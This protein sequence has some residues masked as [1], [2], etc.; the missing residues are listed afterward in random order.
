MLATIGSNEYRNR[1]MAAGAAP[2]PLTPSAASTGNATASAASGAIRMP[3]SAIDGIVCTMF[4]APSTAFRRRG[5]RWQSTPSGS[6]TIT[7][8]PS[9]PRAS[10][11]CRCASCA[12]RV[13]FTAYSR[14]IERS[15]K[16]PEP[17][18]ASVTARKHAERRDAQR[19]AGSHARQ[20]I[21]G[22]QAERDQHDP[23]SGAG[24]DAHDAIAGGRQDVRCR[25]DRDDQRRHADERGQ[26]PSARAL[27]EH[28][29]GSGGRQREIQ[30]E[31]GGGQQVVQRARLARHDAVG[32]EDDQRQQ[33]EGKRPHQ[34][35]QRAQ[36]IDALH[37][38]WSPWL[39]GR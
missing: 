3:K 18:A 27:D 10:S 24:C 1:A 38:V 36:V 2:M 12:N 34:A 19:G 32:L 21:G 4:S 17:S 11:R 7:A 25:C 15:S 23:E 28:G 5:W 14:M 39:I 22:E 6:A 26:Q 31:R 35:Q 37:A 8:A 33:R 9:E 20:G 30:R 16:K 13:A 29:D